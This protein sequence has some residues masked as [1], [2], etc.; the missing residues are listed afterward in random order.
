MDKSTHNLGTQ[1]KIYILSQLAKT[2]PAKLKIDTQNLIHKTEV[3]LPI[4]KYKIHSTL[5]DM[6]WNNVAWK[7][8]DDGRRCLAGI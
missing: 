8:S 3:V 6:A 7:R 2:P 5:D 4:L 1:E